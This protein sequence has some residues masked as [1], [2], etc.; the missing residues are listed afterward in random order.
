MRASRRVY[1][2]P[3][4][5][6]TGNL[7]CGTMAIFYAV[8]DALRLQAGDPAA[9]GFGEPFVMACWLVVAAG[10]FD[11]F[12]GFVARLTSTTSK[13]GAELDSLSDLISFGLAPA[14]I[15]YLSVLRSEKVG[16]LVAVAFVVAVAM[17]LA[18]YNTSTGRESKSGF[19]GLPSPAAGISLV[20]YVLFWRHAGAYIVGGEGISVIRDKAM[21]WYVERVHWIHEMFL[22]IMVAGLAGL[23]VSNLRYPDLR[24]V[25]FRRSVP[26]T[27]GYWMAL[28]VILVIYRPQM[29]VF[30]L[31]VV[32]AGLAPAKWVYA[33]IRVAYPKKSGSQKPWYA[34]GSS[35]GDD[36]GSG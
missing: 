19:Q 10:F 16:T 13:F 30:I 2:L 33:K 11:F 3:T 36:E 34:I 23:M 21:E 5:L 29:M 31:F 1:I 25:L 18:R 28:G 24:K 32:Y 22:P 9:R 7:I 20:S 12:D 15:L 14:M 6:T 27:L 26:L 17:R 35:H 4:L 8:G